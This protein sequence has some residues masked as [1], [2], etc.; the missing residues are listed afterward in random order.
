MA[1]DI[2]K[3]LQRR[4]KLSNAETKRPD[5]R[6]AAVR[7][8]AV[9]DVLEWLRRESGHMQLTLVSAVDWIEDGEFE[10]VWL[11]TDPNAHTTLMLST[12]VARDRAS[13][14]TVHDLWPQAVT[15][16]QELNEMFGI[17]FEG[18]P[19]QG[20]PFILEGWRDLPPMRRDF[21]TAAYSLS[22]YEGRPGRRYIDA[23]TFIGE[24]SGEKG[25]SNE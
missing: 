14:P 24:K 12:R 25:Y 7:P 20:V 18:S 22:H 2:L 19:R 10:I 23:R 5:L 8:G 6:A 4:F 11:V 21:D 3:E 9:R 16:E 1:D 13:L 15:Y 17:L